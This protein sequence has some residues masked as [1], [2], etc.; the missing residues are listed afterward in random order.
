MVKEYLSKDKIWKKEKRKKNCWEDHDD[1]I[2]GTVLR[3]KY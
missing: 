3:N 2:E 1:S